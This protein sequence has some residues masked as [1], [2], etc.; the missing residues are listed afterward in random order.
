M[1]P[2][3]VLPDKNKEGMAAQ[4]DV[5]PATETPPAAAVATVTSDKVASPEVGPTE[6]LC[7]MVLRPDFVGYGFKLHEDTERKQEFVASVE[8]GSPAEAA[9]L[10]VKDVIIEVNGAKVEGASHQDVLRRIMSVPN[11]ALLLVANEATCRGNRER[12]VTDSDTLPSVVEL[13]GAEAA[14]RSAASKPESREAG[15][16]SASSTPGVS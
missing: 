13:S 12:G 11:E 9:G 15:V 14:D 10:R 2:P 6:R 4:Q 1:E 5:P 7:R 16:A 8:Q 3:S